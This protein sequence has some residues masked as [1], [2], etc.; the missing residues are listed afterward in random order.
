MNQKHF[1]RLFGIDIPIGP[2][3]PDSRPEAASTPVNPDPETGVYN[4][5]QYLICTVE[6]YSDKFSF[7]CVKE[8]EKQPKSKPKP[9]PRPAPP[10]PDELI[11]SS[12]FS[13][14]SDDDYVGEE[15]NTGGGVSVPPLRA[16]KPREKDK[17]ETKKVGE[18][19]PNR[20]NLRR[21]KAEVSSDST[22]EVKQEVKVFVLPKALPS[23]VSLR[24]RASDTVVT[25]SNSSAAESITNTI[26]ADDK[27]SSTI[28][29][30]KMASV[31]LTPS[32]ASR[33]VM[34]DSVQTK[35]SSHNASGILRRSTEEPT[36][37]RTAL[38]SNSPPPEASYGL[39]T[40]MSS[41]RGLVSAYTSVFASD[42]SVHTPSLSALRTTDQTTKKLYFA[43]GQSIHVLDPLTFPER[44]EIQPQSTQYQFL[45][46]TRLLV[47]FASILHPFLTV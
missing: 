1:T 46:T 4:Y 25:H 17:E 27:P 10:E 12:E 3:I 38:R 40:S 26:T 28:E 8:Q 43:P 29:T 2:S 37:L 7:C 35:G 11:S 22:P 24:K 21:R 32:I 30:P 47:C 44:P 16:V 18:P 45:Q 31:H 41:G 19:A 33:D 5:I 9:K 34:P 14:D 13:D 42:M 23:D 20:P 6:K 39:S 15:G 36:R